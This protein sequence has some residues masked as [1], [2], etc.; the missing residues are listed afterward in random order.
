MEEAVQEHLPD[1]E[2]GPAARRD[3]DEGE[4]EE[5][6]PDEENGSAARRDEASSGTVR[7][8]YGEQRSEEATQQMARYRR[9][10][11]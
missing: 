3:E 6:F 2:N 4:V 7:G 10:E 1:D 11:R 5:H 8:M 9:P